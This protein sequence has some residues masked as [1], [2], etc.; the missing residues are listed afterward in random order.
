MG[1]RK[2]AD[3]VCFL[4]FQINSA[5]VKPEMKLI[6]CSFQSSQLHS[7]AGENVNRACNSRA[8]QT[9]HRFQN[10]RV[11]GP[12]AKKNETLAWALEQNHVEGECVFV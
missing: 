10:G 8:G 5:V 1:G 11:R 12:H 6:P 3:R 4:L 7:E 9:R 2:Q